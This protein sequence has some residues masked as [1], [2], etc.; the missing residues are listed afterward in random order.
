MDTRERA[1]AHTASKVGMVASVKAHRLMARSSTSTR[2]HIHE[3]LTNRLAFRGVM[4]VA[5]AD[6]HCLTRIATTIEPVSGRHGGWRHVSHMTVLPG[7]ILVW[8]AHHGSVVNGHVG[9]VSDTA[10]S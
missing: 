6:A 7:T 3:F 8:N 4:I 2:Q 5:V 1:Y 10:V 9:C